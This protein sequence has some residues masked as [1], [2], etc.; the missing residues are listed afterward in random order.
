VNTS[1][2]TSPGTLARTSLDEH[3]PTEASM[4]DVWAW[5]L[6]HGDDPKIIVRDIARWVGAW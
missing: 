3:H 6:R 1:S 4:V 5:A 2:T